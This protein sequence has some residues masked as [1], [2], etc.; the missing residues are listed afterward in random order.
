MAT[1]RVIRLT[2]PYLVI[3]RKF[4]ICIAHSRVEYPLLYV[5]DELVSRAR[6][7]KVRVNASLSI[8]RKLIHHPTKPS[9]DATSAPGL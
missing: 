7:T 6:Q 4:S 1:A 3:R 2:G 5:G 9:L 8:Y